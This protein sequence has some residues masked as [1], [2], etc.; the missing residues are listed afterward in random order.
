MTGHLFLLHHAVPHGSQVLLRGRD[1]LLRVF[2]QV[3][4]KPIDRQVLVRSAKEPLADVLG[5]GTN[6]VGHVL[7]SERVVHRWAFKQLTTECSALVRLPL[8]D[9]LRYVQYTADIPDRHTCET[10]KDTLKP[11]E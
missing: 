6:F 1:Q 7:A 11:A 3:L 5:E 10:H 9:L 4:C 8:G 2:D